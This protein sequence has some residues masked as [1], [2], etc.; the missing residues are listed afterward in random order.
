MLISKGIFIAFKKNHLKLDESKVL[1]G[2]A[3]QP[4]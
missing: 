3:Q 2:V 1:N 4:G